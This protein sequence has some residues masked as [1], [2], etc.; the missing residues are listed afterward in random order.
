MSN[1]TVDHDLAD[2]FVAYI[3][4]SAIICVVGTLC[5]SACVWCLVNCPKT[6]VG[7]KVQLGCFFGLLVVQCALTGPL[8]LVSLNSGFFCGSLRPHFRAWTYIFRIIVVEL[9]RCHFAVMAVY[10]LLA[11]RW[12]LLYQRACEVKMVVMSEAAVGVFTT[13]SWF[14]PLF[15]KTL[16]V[17]DFLVLVGKAKADPLTYSCFR[18]LFGLS[19]VV[20]LGIGLIAYVTLMITA[21]IVTV[22]IKRTSES[23]VCIKRGFIRNM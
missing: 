13:A 12:P 16:E 21:S 18:L 10:R 3:V 22:Y 7:M 1:C 6:N 11:V 4:V 19:Y 14:S 8:G 15:L 2:S 23:T 17:E 5:N 20:P 9:E